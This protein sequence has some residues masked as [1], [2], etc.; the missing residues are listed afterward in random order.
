M[1]LT[2]PVSPTAPESLDDLDDFELIGDDLD[3]LLDSVPNG[4]DETEVPVFCFFVCLF[5]F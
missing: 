4:Q 2:A 1:P 3:I 5:G